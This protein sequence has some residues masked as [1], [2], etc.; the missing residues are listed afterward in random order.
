MLKTDEIKIV[1]NIELS[2]IGVLNINMK[3]RGVSLE[4]N[5]VSKELLQKV[6]GDL[7]VL[8]NGGMNSVKVYLDEHKT[9]AAKTDQVIGTLQ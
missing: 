2:G 9:D 5:G 8:I 4:S 3:P 7:Q 1:V 6:I